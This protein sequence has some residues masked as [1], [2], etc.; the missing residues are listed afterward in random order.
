MATNSKPNKW[1]ALFTTILAIIP[2]V[3]DAWGS[4]EEKSSPVIVQSG[5]DFGEVKL[6][7]LPS[8]LGALEDSIKLDR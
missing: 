1:L 6:V 3:L 7:I 8:E 2:V 5:K 4:E